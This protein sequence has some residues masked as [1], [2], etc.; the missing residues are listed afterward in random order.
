MDP[1]NKH[2]APSTKHYYDAFHMCRQRDRIAEISCLL[3]KSEV[4]MTGFGIHVCFCLVNGQLYQLLII[5]LPQS[6]FLLKKKF[7]HYPTCNSRLNFQD[8]VVLVQVRYQFHTLLAGQWPNSFQIGIIMEFAKWV[9]LNFNLTN[10]CL[11]YK[12]IDLI[13]QVQQLGLHDSQ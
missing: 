5:Q 4:K 10:Q 11:T 2:Q 7:D 1:H 13:I 6:Y 9:L 12:S 8:K 3:I